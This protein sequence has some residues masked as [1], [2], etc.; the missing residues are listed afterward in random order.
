MDPRESVTIAGMLPAGQ[1]RVEVVDVVGANA[2]IDMAQ[3]FYVLNAVPATF[4][5]NINVATS[6]LGHKLANGVQR[7]GC[8]LVIA[9]PVVPK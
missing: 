2:I 9:T 7:R 8:T 5:G 6:V 3:P 4:S 1:Y